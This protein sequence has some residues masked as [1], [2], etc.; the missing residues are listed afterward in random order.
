MIDVSRDGG[1]T[2]LT[3]NRPDK[4]NAL[5][6]DMLTALAD[7]VEAASLDAETR[8]IVLTGAGKVFSAGADLEAAKAGLAKDPVW[9]RLSNAVAACPVLTIAALNGTAAG[10]ALGMVLAADMRVAA[11]HTKTFY[12]VMALGFLPQPSDPIRMNALAGR[13]TTHRVL[14]CGEKLTADM[15]LS[16]GL[17]D[18]ISDDPLAEARRLA[19]AAL[20]ATRDHVAAIKAMI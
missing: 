16:C 15:A 17:I 9:E 11:S 13:A 6:R 14:M 8:A 2:V 10:G 12:P 1:L 5:T 4:A 7:A 3:L 19:S 20:S 18:V